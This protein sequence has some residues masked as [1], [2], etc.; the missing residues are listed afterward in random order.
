MTLRHPVALY[1]HEAIHSCIWYI[2]TYTYVFCE[3]SHTFMYSIYHSK[4]T[5]VYSY[6]SCVMCSPLK[7]SH[8]IKKKSCIMQSPLQK[9]LCSGFSTPYA[10]FCLICTIHSELMYFPIWTTNIFAGVDI[11]GLV[12]DKFNTFWIPKRFSCGVWRCVHIWCI[13]YQIHVNIS[14]HK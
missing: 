11:R 5:Y 8:I 1:S 10:T 9:V 7:K 3:Y 2:L 14:N 4:N 13:L 6:E 12:G